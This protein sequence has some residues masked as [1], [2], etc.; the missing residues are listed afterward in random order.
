MVTVVFRSRLREANEAG[1][2]SL[3]PKILELAQSMP[4]FVSFK[5][6]TAEDGERVSIGQFESLEALEAWRKHPE[7]LA[8]QRRGREEFYAEYSL[9]VCTPIRAY[10]FDG[11]DR[12][13]L[14]RSA[15]P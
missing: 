15:G 11:R 12:F 8:A 6:F 10:A 14:P 2:R 4:G 5:S 13:D 7:H 3:A 1:Y 9:E